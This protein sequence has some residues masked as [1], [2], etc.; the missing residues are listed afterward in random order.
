MQVN[1]EEEF[2]GAITVCDENGTILDMNNKAEAS[3]ANDGG[4]QLLGKNLFDCHSPESVIKINEL[5][6][7]NKTNVYTIEKNGV[8]KLIYQSPWYKD[9]ALKGLVEFSL[10]IPSA[11]PHFIRS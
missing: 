8:H 6:A 5:L 9:G 1:W 3:F 7:E 2:T 11:M 10:E 4:R